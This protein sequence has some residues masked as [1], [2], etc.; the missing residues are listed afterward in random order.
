MPKHSTRLL[1]LLSAALLTVAGAKTSTNATVLQPGQ[2]AR[3]M[4]LDVQ[5]LP[6]GTLTITPGTYYIPNY[7][8]TGISV[9]L[10]SP[11]PLAVATPDQMLG[12]RAVWKR[13]MAGLLSS[14][15]APALSPP[16]E[17]NAVKAVQKT[18][19]PAVLPAMTSAARA[20]PGTPSAPQ[21]KQAAPAAPVQAVAPAPKAPPAAPAFPA[22][23]NVFALPPAAGTFPESKNVFKTPAAPRQSAFPDSKN[24]FGGTQAVPAPTLTAPDGPPTL[25]PSYVDMKWRGR[26]G[27]VTAYITNLSKDKPLRIDPASLRI[28]QN[29]SPLQ[30]QLSVRDSSGATQPS[31][32]LPRSMFTVMVRVT[33]SGAGPLTLTWEARDDAGTVYPVRY[34][35]L[36]Q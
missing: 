4:P 18:S 14:T 2:P 1:T 22:A 16:A 36:P 12:A 17:V 32:L 25:V 23:K 29:G 19:R 21:R 20:A 33:P 5:L 10:Q 26:G 28:Y 7:E 30:A 6:P 9:Y 35:W 3:T 31:T 24:A 13:V 34:S 11:R 27:V 15:S 8:Q